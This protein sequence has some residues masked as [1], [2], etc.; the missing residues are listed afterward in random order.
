[1]QIV[2]REMKPG[3]VVLELTGPLQMG[4]ECKQLELA[5]DEL[6][7]EHQKRVVLDLTHLTR[8]DSGGLGRVVECFSR[9]KMAGGSLCLAGANERVEGVLELTH[10]NKFLKA[11]PTVADA[12]A[13]FSNPPQ[14]SAR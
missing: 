10:A 9:L 13:S 5:F 6:L 7:K 12:A 11:Y 3:I 1:M 4:V 14:A 2:K 8:L